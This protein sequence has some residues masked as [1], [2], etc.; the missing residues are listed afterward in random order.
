[1]IAAGVLI[2]VGNNIEPDKNP[3]N[4]TVQDS[5]LK[6]NLKTKVLSS[7]GNKRRVI[8]KKES[9]FQFS[10]MKKIEGVVDEISILSTS[11]SPVKSGKS[12]LIIKLKNKKEKIFFYLG[13]NL[14]EKQIIKKSDLLSQ[15]NSY[16]FYLDPKPKS[17]FFDEPK[18]YDLI[19]VFVKSSNVSNFFALFLVFIGLISIFFVIK[20]R[21]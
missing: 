20:L 3:V 13:N 10:E 16:I 9:K 21:N 11:I 4:K 12:Y 14:S 15:G 8:L 1:M 2:Y 18:H 19:E 5:S 17:F 7:L 6:N